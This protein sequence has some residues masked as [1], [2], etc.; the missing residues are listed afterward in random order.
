MQSSDD[1]AADEEDIQG[2][3]AVDDMDAAGDD[4]DDDAPEMP[5]PSSSDY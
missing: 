2:P 3:P 1:E 4:L 5:A